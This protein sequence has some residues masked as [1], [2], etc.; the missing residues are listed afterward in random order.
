M[1]A[2]DW[3]EFKHLDLDAMKSSMR[4]PIVIDGRNIYEPE[5]V[6]QKG[7][8]YYGIGRGTLETE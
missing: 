5:V 7:F 3:N 4:Q 6:R 1:I 2:T 8:I